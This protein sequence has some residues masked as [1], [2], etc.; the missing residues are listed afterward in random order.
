MFEQ[1]KRGWL[2]RKN[3]PTQLRTDRTAGTCDHD[4][5]AFDT[6]LQKIRLSWNGIAPQ[7]VRNIDFLNIFD[8]DPATRQIGK[9][10][11]TANVQW[12]AFQQVK[13]FPAPSTSRGWQSEKD[14]LRPCDV[15]HLLNMLGFINLQA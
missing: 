13:N 6:T 11:H 12:K 9:I 10:R 8:L 1:Q 2:Q 4:S 5:L 3:L 14:F 7:Q 15:D